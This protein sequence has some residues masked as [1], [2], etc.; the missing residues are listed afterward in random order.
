MYVRG[1]KLTPL[2]FQPKPPPLE[3]NLYVLY[4]IRSLYIRKSSERFTTNETP[5][6]LHEEVIEPKNEQKKNNYC[7][8]TINIQTYLDKIP[9]WVMFFLIILFILILITIIVL[10]ILDYHNDLAEKEKYEELDEEFS[11]F[12][13]NKQNQCAIANMQEQMKY[14]QKGTGKNIDSVVANPTFVTECSELI[15][16][17]TNLVG[18]NDIIRFESK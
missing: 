16:N 8:S 17:I 3:L 2:P 4:F 14:Y 12:K 15:L 7:N 10:I 9:K 1:T 5:D 18:D 11:L 6:L 13:K